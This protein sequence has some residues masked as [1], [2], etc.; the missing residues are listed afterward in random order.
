MSDP[1]LAEQFE[2]IQYIWKMQFEKDTQLS[3]LNS[4]KIEQ[5]NPYFQ[6]IKLFPF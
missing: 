3:L 1:D 5:N 2:N 6:N 4:F